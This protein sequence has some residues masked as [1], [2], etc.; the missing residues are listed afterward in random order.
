M[1]YLIAVGFGA[2]GGFAETFFN[3][4]ET[5]SARAGYTAAGALIGLV[6][7]AP[8]PGVSTVVDKL[9]SMV[10]SQVPQ[11]Q[12]VVIALTVLFLHNCPGIYPVVF[13]TLDLPLI[14]KFMGK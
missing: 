9:V 1:E 3:H 11:A 13:K 8:I 2:A 10:P 4:S 14:E 6:L 7:A 5:N 12:G